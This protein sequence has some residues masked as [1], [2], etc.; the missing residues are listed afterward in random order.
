MSYVTG[1]KCIRC[2]AE[3]PVDRMF[4][5]CP[6]HDGVLVANVTPTYDYDAIGRAFSREALRDRPPTMWRYHEFLPADEADIV[7]IG[8]GF[9]PLVPCPT[10][11][12]AVGLP[13]LYVKDEGRNATWSFKDR[14]ASSAISMG[15]R[16]GAEVITASSSGNAGS[17][18]GA[19]AA[20]AGLDCVLFSTQQFPLTMKVHMQ[21]Y[22]SKLIACPTI[23]DRWRMVKL[24]VERLGWYPTAGFNMPMVGCN[25]YGVDGYKTLAYETIEQLGWRAPDVVIMPVGGGD[26]F[27]GTWK[28]FKEWHDRGYIER[29]PRMIAAEIFGS[30]TNAVAKDLDHVE[31]VPYGPTVGISAGTYTSTYQALTVLRESNGLPRCVGDEGMIAMQRALATTEG[32]FAEMSSVLSVAAAKILAGEGTIDPD[33][34]VVCVLTATG[35]KDPDTTARQMPEIPLIEPNLASL[36]EALARTYGMEIGVSA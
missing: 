11:G 36:G 19:Y 24:C 1:L 33:A 26:A 6:Q 15:R 31:P 34:V 30:L 13:N 9:T 28:G 10:L 35:L 12:K 3:Y 8:E 17:A 2:G 27:F 5:G 29:L 20:R 14:M 7:T 22:G 18:T 21:A 16:F 23:E 32:V 4:Q 25:P